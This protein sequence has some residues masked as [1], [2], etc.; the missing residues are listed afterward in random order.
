MRTKFLLLKG[1]FSLLLSLGACAGK[2]DY[3]VAPVYKG[4]PEGRFPI[5]ATYAFY[6]PY[7]TDRQMEWVAEAGFNAVTKVLDSEDTDS[8]LRL[9]QKHGMPVLVAD[10]AVRNAKTVGGIINKYADNQCVWGYLLIDEPKAS[11]FPAIA[12]VDSIINTRHPDG[13]RMYN[14]LPAVWPRDLGAKDYATY[15]EDF[16]CTVNPSFLSFDIY[17]VKLDKQNRLYVEPL[18]YPTLEEVR[19]VS[20]ESGRPFWSYVL[21]NKHWN[22][23]KPTREFL[24]FAIFTALAYGSQGLSYYTYLMPD[25]DKDV[26]EYSFAPIDWNGNRT[27][28]WY[29]VRDVNTEVRNLEDIF[30]GAEIIEVSQTGKDIPNGTKRFSTLPAPFTSLESYGVGLTVSHLQNDNN[31]YIILV[32]RDIQNK[33]RVKLASKAPVTRFTGDGERKTFKG[34]SFVLPPGGYAI[35]RF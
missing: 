10:R 12:T 35:F 29:M 2:T 18:L 9:A 21:S 31:E 22:Y 15:L 32:N 6:H 1:L 19:R 33:Q 5:L 3:P 26:G 13:L 20:K 23:P 27:D 4:H 25:F 17:P 7:M 16:V 14:L 24:R 30:L 34:G 11:S 8:L 28:V